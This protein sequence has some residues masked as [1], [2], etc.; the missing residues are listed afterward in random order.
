[1][2]K[3]YDK[4]EMLSAYIDGEL[5]DEEIK[6]LEEELKFSKELQDKLNELKR[7]KQLTVSSFKAY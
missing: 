7:I 4:Y 5:S 3:R 2:M 1:M 6:S